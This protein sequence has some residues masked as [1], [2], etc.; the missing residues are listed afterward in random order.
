MLFNIA[1]SFSLALSNLTENFPTRFSDN[2]QNLNLVLDLVFTQ[3]SSMEFN[4][5]HIHPDWRL[6]SNHALITV[7]IHINDEN[8]STKWHSLI[9]GSDK[10]KQFIKDL[11]WFIKNLNTSP[12]QDTKSLEEVV[13]H[14]ATNIEDIWFKYSK[15]VNI[16]R[17][18]KAWWNKDCRHTLQ[19]YR[20]SCSLEN[21][22]NFK[23]MVK[24]SKCSFFDKKI[25]EIKNK[26]CSL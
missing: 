18:S 4:H 20:Q 15:I 6:I 19:K 14:L 9:K 12:I 7:N 10:E 5:H 1:D 26:K 22:K 23:S 13:Q 16:T 8:I 2:D 25:D 24:K 3:P 11:T 21:W 17:Y